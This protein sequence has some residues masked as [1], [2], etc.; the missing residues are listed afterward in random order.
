V[1]PKVVITGIG[2]VTPVGTGVEDFWTGLT[3]GR[4]GIGPIERFD[5][6]DLPVTLARRSRLRRVEVAR[7]EGD[8][9]DQAVDA[10]AIASRLA[11][12]D[13]EADVVAGTAAWC[14]DGIAPSRRS[15]NR[16]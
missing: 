10:F 15:S 11:W 1:G 2:P 4:N 7:H 8:A 12:Q 9:P 6:S 16:R 14:S 3:S 13:A 5:P